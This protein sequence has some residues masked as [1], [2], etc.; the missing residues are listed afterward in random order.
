MLFVDLEST[1]LG[2][3]TLHSWLLRNSRPDY[4]KKDDRN[5]NNTRAQLTVISSSVSF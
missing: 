5:E 3:K 2:G 1:F 4:A